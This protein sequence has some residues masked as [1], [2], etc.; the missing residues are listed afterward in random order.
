MKLDFKTLRHVYERINSILEK[1]NNE[2]K[3]IPETSYSSG[4]KTGIYRL[5][6]AI[7]LEIVDMEISTLKVKG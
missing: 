7:G 2:L 5:A 6:N 4:I 3:D 1:M